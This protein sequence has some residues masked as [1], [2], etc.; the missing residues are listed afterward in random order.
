MIALAV[1]SAGEA[2]A[3]RNTKSHEDGFS[4]VLVLF[5]A[6]CPPV[7]RQR[8]SRIAGL[9]QPSNNEPQPSSNDDGELSANKGWDSRRLHGKRCVFASYDRSGRRLSKSNRRL[10]RSNRL[11]SLL[12]TNASIETVDGCTLA[13]GVIADTKTSVFRH[14]EQKNLTPAVTER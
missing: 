12:R 1:G 9:R 10:S 6:N 13:G 7:S 5:V 3:T 14:R 2:I 11:R 4:C 8:D